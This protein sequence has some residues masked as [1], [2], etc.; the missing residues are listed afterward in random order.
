[1]LEREKYSKAKA[2][3]WIRKHK[4]TGQLDASW[5]K[6]FYRFRQHPPGHYV[7]GSFRTITMSPTKGI[8][9]VVGCPRPQYRKNPPNEW[10]VGFEMHLGAGVYHIDARI[11]WEM[12]PG[13]DIWETPPE[14]DVDV[15][16]RV[17]VDR[18][19]ELGEAGPGR[20]LTND[21]VKAMLK[22]HGEEIERMVYGFAK[23]ESDLAQ[24]DE[25]DDEGSYTWGDSPEYDENGPYYKSYQVHF[26]R[27]DGT[28]AQAIF[29][30]EEL[31]KAYAATL[32]HSAHAKI[33]VRRLKPR[34]VQ[35]ETR[36]RRQT[37]VEEAEMARAAEEEDRARRRA[38][39]MYDENPYRVR[40]VNKDGTPGA[41]TFPTEQL[42]AAYSRSV[43]KPVIELVGGEAAPV[44]I[45]HLEAL[46]LEASKARRH[47]VG[48]TRAA[49]ERAVIKE[50]DVEHGLVPPPEPKRRRGTFIP[51]AE[52]E[53]AWAYSEDEE[54]GPDLPVPEYNDNPNLYEQARAQ[55][56]AEALGARTRI[57]TTLDRRTREQINA[58]L[59]EAGLDGNGNFRGPSHGIAATFN[60]LDDFG[61]TVDDV[62]GPML[63][64]DLFM[65]DSGKRT[66]NLGVP[67]PDQPFMPPTPIENSMLVFSWYKRQSGNYEILAYV[68]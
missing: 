60:V 21:E 64:G 68:S 36:V 29:P 53:R 2:K 48:A 63:S 37:S 39:G 30:T 6:R 43:K 28:P 32:S 38:V 42:A 18:V 24:A 12:P 22:L 61:I 34:P 51:T 14:A 41:A 35:F 7:K 66:I 50:H 23:M 62:T 31:A 11:L 59:A 49:H 65:G 10:P 1:M 19:V 25:S 45:H 46:D 40:F 52:Q 13:I 27:K 4:F 15:E 33:R 3:T 56:A 55:A 57:V 44:E 67:V 5:G 8:K 20:D 26:T 17:E 47:Q 54:A 9:A 16:S 58:A